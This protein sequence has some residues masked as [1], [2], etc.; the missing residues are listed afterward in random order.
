MLLTADQSIVIPLSEKQSKSNAQEKS[1]PAKQSGTQPASG[2]S[3]RPSP[4]P[5]PESEK[6]MKPIRSLGKSIEKLF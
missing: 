4:S 6:V 5:S 1:D 2:S 3:S